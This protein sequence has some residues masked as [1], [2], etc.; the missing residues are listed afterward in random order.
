[1]P[2]TTLAPSELRNSDQHR[3]QSSL[4][5]FG[6]QAKPK[7]PRE[8]VLHHPMATPPPEDWILF[9]DEV[10]ITKHSSVRRRRS[11]KIK[12]PQ[13]EDSRRPWIRRDPSKEKSADTS[14]VHQDAG[15]FKC[16]PSTPTKS[17]DSVAHARESNGCEA[18]RQPKPKFPDRLPTP[19]LSDIEEDGFWSCCGSSE[20]ST[21]RELDSA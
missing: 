13:P 7:T 3:H 17:P 9:P 10:I 15:R 18:K 5:L 14:H 1:M 20:S 21:L 16:I 12:N 2:S 6:K 19:D 11:S 8:V 4:T